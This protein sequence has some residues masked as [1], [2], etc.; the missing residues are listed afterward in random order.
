VADF[1]TQIAVSN[2]HVLYLNALQDAMSDALVRICL[3]TSDLIYVS[4]QRTY[5][6]GAAPDEITVE[7]TSKERPKP[8][9][10]T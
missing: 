4:L 5:P 9:N 8:I 3:W 1:Y 7:V 10:F 2:T 6:E